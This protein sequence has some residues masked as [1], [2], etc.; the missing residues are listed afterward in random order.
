[1]L[2]TVTAVY[3]CVA[4][5]IQGDDL[6]EAADRIGSWLAQ[7]SR[8]TRALLYTS[9]GVIKQ[10]MYISHMLVALRFS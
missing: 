1:M 9:L 3:T 8:G 7:R 6:N 10:A 5:D 4:K 2:V